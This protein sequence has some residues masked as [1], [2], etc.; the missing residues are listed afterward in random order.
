MKSFYPIKKR[1]TSK[2]HVNVLVN[3]EEIKEGMT[4]ET[5]KLELLKKPCLKTKLVSKITPR[6]VDGRIE[7][8]FKDQPSS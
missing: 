5:P 3:P 2:I 7:F 8:V 6:T 1:D 4:I